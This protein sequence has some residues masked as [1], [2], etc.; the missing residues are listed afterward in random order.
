MALRTLLSSKQTCRSNN[1]SSIMPRPTYLCLRSG[2]ILQ[3]RF[4]KYYTSA[5]IILMLWSSVTWNDAMCEELWVSTLSKNGGSRP[6][7]T[8]AN[9]RNP[10]PT[11]TWMICT[12]S[13]TERTIG[14]LDR[15]RL[16]LTASIG[17]V[18]C[19]SQRRKNRVDLARMLLC[20]ATPLYHNH[21]VHVRSV[22]YE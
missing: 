2:N 18:L 17:A 14:F 8:R 5:Y 3:V 6:N 12:T 9:T 20:Y 1:L 15:L 13:T 11:N 7:S 4:R 21:H 16:G 22:Q 19:W 10:S